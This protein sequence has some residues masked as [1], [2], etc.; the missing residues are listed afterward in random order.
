[1][2]DTKILRIS[3]EELSAAADILKSG[4]TVVFPTETVYGLGAN[5]LSDEAV[6]KI[7]EAK[8]RPSDNPLIVHIYDRKQLNDI[9]EEIPSDVEKLMD[10]FWP[11]PLTVILKKRPEIPDSV[12]AGLDTVGV[13]MP[14]N[15]TALKLLSMADVPI[16]APSANISGRPSPTELSHCL[17]DMNGRV[18]AIIDGGPCSVGVES[19]VIDMT[20]E[21]VIYRPGD[22][23]VQQIED[24]LGKPVRIA[25]ELHDGEKAKSPGLKYR[26]YS[27]KAE[28]VVLSGTLGEV[29][30]AVNRESR[31]VGIISFDEQ[32]DT[33]KKEF[34]LSIRLLSLGSAFSPKDAEARLFKCLREM[35]SYGVNVVFAPEIPDS[36]NW[37]AVRNRLYRAASGRVV[38]AKKYG[39]DGSEV[40]NS[41]I[42]KI[43]FVCTGNT[44]RSPM[45]EGLFN[46]YAEEEG[47]ECR[48]E[49]AGLFASAGSKPSENAVA[50]AAEDG[51]DIS[52]HRSVRFTEETIRS[53]DL[54][55]TMSKSH[56]QT[57]EQAYP[58]AD[59]KVYTLPEYIGNSTFTDVFDPFGGDMQVY[60]TC[61][62]VLKLFVK[63]LVEKMITQSG[64]DN[65]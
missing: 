26:H 55:L 35:D 43:V 17:L 58:S 60:R 62:G 54:I 16:A 42:K 4:G 23:T 6:S 57:L 50:V 7:F 27:P 39:G 12:T 32:I 14:G 52:E 30:S 18:D 21:P 44:C 11:G 51:I 10:N 47:L 56:K 15:D 8:G 61:F 49:S 41:Y 46:F 19:T 31:S 64:A 1:M 9:A 28:V 2:T 25:A 5:A 33:L 48:A 40:S 3:D 29:I 38:P 22:I 13:R 34:G 65:V 53:A 59:D 45:A 37:R 63:S 36:D 24:V 20:D